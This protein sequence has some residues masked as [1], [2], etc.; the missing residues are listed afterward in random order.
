MNEVVESAGNDW[1]CAREEVLDV[2]VSGTCGKVSMSLLSAWWRALWISPNAS[3][4]AQCRSYEK[5][6]EGVGRRARVDCLMGAVVAGA[7]R[8]AV[9]GC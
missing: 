4:S 8:S 9:D 2:A 6:T 5:T 1:R 7:V 3:G